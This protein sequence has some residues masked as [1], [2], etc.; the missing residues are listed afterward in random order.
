[1]VCGELGD[2]HEALDAGKNLD[3]RAERDDLRH[4]SFDDVL[5]AVALD[6]LLPRIRLRLLE[7]E[8]DP[9]AVAVDVEH[10]HLDGLTD[11]EHLGGMVHVAPRE[12]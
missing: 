2:V 11:V 4:T 12:L 1:M 3:E 7:A 6:D 9:L 5:F 10:L 8:R